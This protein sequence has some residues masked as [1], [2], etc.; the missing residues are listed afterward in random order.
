MFDDLSGNRALVTG[1]SGG[2]GLHFAKLL[3]RHGADVTL[4]ARRPAALDKACAEIAAEGGKAGVLS[5]DV[6]DSASIKEALAGRSFDI[7]INN[8]GIS[9]AGRALD[10]SRGRL[11]SR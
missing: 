2:L 10:L 1:A 4:A 11:G 6:V 8:A 7:L 9:G 3:A 5:L